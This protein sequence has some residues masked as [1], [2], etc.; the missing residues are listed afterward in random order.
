MVL[1]RRDTGELQ[2]IR[3]S[4]RSYDAL[5]Y[6]LMFWEGQDGYHLNIRM[7]DPLTGEYG[8]LIPSRR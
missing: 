4:H 5:Q 8:R 3:K 7:V 6:L 1:A 2:R